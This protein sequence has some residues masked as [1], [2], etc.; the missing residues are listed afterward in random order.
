MK[1]QKEYISLGKIENEFKCSK[2]RKKMKFKDD[3]KEKIK[4][5]KKRKKILEYGGIY[6]LILY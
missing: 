3:V 4:Y 2:K 6:Y 5:E 1:V